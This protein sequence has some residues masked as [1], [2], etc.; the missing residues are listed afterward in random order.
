MPKTRRAHQGAPPK[1]TLSIRSK[2]PAQQVDS[3]A[4]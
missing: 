3:S 4:S 1:T 2:G